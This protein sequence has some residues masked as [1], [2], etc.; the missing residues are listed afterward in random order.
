MKKGNLV[1]LTVICVA[2]LLVWFSC[3]PFQS[4]AH[5]TTEF[6]VLDSADTVRATTITSGADL[7][8]AIANALPGDVITISGTI[9]ATGSVKLANSGTSSARITLQG[10][11]ID[12]SAAG[13][14][15]GLS[16]SGAYWTVS[17]VELY[18]GGGR[19]VQIAGGTYNILQNLNVHNN[20]NMGI[21]INQGGSNNQV[22]GC[23]ASENYDVSTGGENADGFAV[24]NG[25]GLG[26]SFTNC[27]SHHNSDDGWDLY[28]F[29][30]SVTFNSCTAESNGYGSQGDGDG[31]KLGGPTSGSHANHVLNNCV[32]NYNN[33]YGYSQNYNPSSITLNNCTGTGN[34]KGLLGDGL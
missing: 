24:K 5:S 32:A 11:K 29:T 9:T 7:Q 3:N 14:S 12:C 6:N 16:I 13:T 28:E 25:A 34:L 1:I 22:I 26:N 20:A 2:A 18:N 27:I 8:G 19:G 33:L 4:G 21:E 10:G 15:A 17:G 31:W 23:T 30:D